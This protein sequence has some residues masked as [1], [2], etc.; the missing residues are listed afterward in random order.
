MRKS[1]LDNL[2]AYKPT[3]TDNGLYVPF[4]VIGLYK[5]DE[6]PNFHCLISKEMFVEMYN[7]WIKE[8]SDTNEV[9]R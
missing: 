9:K 5:K 2:V 4:N 1:I 3:V 6:R 8:D 7:K